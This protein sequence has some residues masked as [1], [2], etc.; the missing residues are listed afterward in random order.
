[1]GPHNCAFT[2]LGYILYIFSGNRTP[3]NV[4]WLSTILWIESDQIYI[5]FRG[6]KYSLSHSSHLPVPQS[7]MKGSLEEADNR[8]NSAAPYSIF[9]MMLSHLYFSSQEQ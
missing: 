5:Y 4:K 1:M 8:Q 6:S 2:I 9:L 7:L 3:D